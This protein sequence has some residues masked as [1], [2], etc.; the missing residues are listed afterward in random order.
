MLG[1]GDGFAG[2]IYRELRAMAAVRMLAERADHTLQPTALVHEAWL[3]MRATPEGRS[4]DSARLRALAGK[5]LQRV[6][7]DHARKRDARK[8][9][10]G[11]RRQPLHSSLVLSSGGERVELADLHRALAALKRRS[12]RQARIVEYR[13]FGGL[14]VA[15]T[16]ALVGVS[17]DT[18][19]REWRVARAWLHRE[20][21]RD[22]GRR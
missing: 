7:L 10:D 14:S 4:L 2:S 18:V 22:G 17:T 16:A 13:Y 5:V 8:R 3:R 11:A 15:D 9:G 6:L 1:L 20:L 12:R 21:E 19:K